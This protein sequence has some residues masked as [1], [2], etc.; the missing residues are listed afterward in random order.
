M[1]ADLFIPLNVQGH[2][3]YYQSHPPTPGFYC[4]LNR[5]LIR[6]LCDP[7]SVLTLPKRRTAVWMRSLVSSIWAGGEFI[8]ETFLPAPE[9]GKSK[10]PVIRSVFH[11]DGEVIVKIN[12][13]LFVRDDGREILAAHMCWS[14]WC[15]AQLVQAL[16]LPHLVQL[17]LSA[18]LFIGPLCFFVGGLQ[19]VWPLQ[20]L[21]IVLSMP[22]HRLLSPAK[23]RYYACSPIVLGGL[24]AVVL[25]SPQIG[26]L[27]LVMVVLFQGG[28]LRQA[29]G[30]CMKMI[31]EKMFGWL[32][33][34]KIRT[35]LKEYS[36]LEL[37]L[38]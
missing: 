30:R 19:V 22:G 5:D 25:G 10:E 26:L 8:C 20:V 13:K 21:G 24:I 29:G 27:Q 7:A 14:S 18:C 33:R 15:L 16:V 35:Y 2:G 36:S 34:W 12:I 37:L 28:M 32:I 17:F 38:L 9:N 23:L 4:L 3:I 6:Q 1:P 31:G 11:L